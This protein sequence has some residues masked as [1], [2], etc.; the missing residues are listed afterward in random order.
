MALAQFKQI[1]LPP[2]ALPK[3]LLQIRFNPDPTATAYKQADADTLYITSSVSN[4][5]Y[6]PNKI[7][8]LA[9]LKKSFND[10]TGKITVDSFKFNVQDSLRYGGI[11]GTSHLGVGTPPI[12]TYV[13]ED[14]TS[15]NGSLFDKQIFPNDDHMCRV[16]AVFIPYVTGTPEPFFCGVIDPKSVPRAHDEIFHADESDETQ[17]IRTLEINAIDI[18]SQFNNFSIQ[19]LLDFYSGVLVPTSVSEHWFIGNVYQ[20]GGV[21]FEEMSYDSTGSAVVGNDL[22]SMSINSF[23]ATM[24]NKADIALNSGNWLASD[25]DLFTQIYDGSYHGGAYKPF[26][27]RTGTDS[28]IPSSY[29][30]DLCFQYNYNIGRGI[31]I[32]DTDD[33][34][35]FYGGTWRRDRKGSDILQ[36]LQNQFGCVFYGELTALG[37]GN[38]ATILKTST[39]R[40]SFGT[41]PTNWK[42]INKS[43]KEDP[44][45][46]SKT[47]VI[48]KYENDDTKLMAGTDDSN[49]ITI[50]MPFRAHQFGGQINSRLMDHIYCQYDTKRGRIDQVGAASIWNTPRAS[51]PDGWVPSKF[52]FVDYEFG[53]SAQTIYPYART[54][55]GSIR[56]GIAG[57]VM[58]GDSFPYNPTATNFD[59]SNGYYNWLQ[60]PAIYYYQELIGNKII[61]NREYI[62]CLSDSNTIQDLRPGIQFTLPKY[63]GKDRTFKIIEL[64][65]DLWKNK[66]KTKSQ[67]VLSSLSTPP[68]KYL[69]GSGSTSSQSSGTT[70]TAPSGLDNSLFVSTLPSSAT[71]N[72]IA[73]TVANALTIAKYGSSAGQ[74]GELRFRTLDDVHY[75]GFKAPDTLAANNIYVLPIAFPTGSPQTLFSTTGGILK[76]VDTNAL[77]TTS[78]EFLLA[79]TAGVNGYPG[80]II[81]LN[82]NGVAL[83]KIAVASANSVLLGSGSS[84]SGSTYSEITLGS[85]LTM[86]GTVLS[87]GGAGLIHITETLRTA[88]PNNT[89]NVE[90]LA[91]NSASPITTNADLSLIPRGTGAFLLATPD[92]SATGGNK[93]GTYAI[94][95]QLTRS[96]NLY[97]ASGSGSVLIG[98]TDNMAI[99][100]YAA[101]VGGS[102]NVANGFYAFVTGNANTVNNDNSAIIGG[103]S[104]TIDG[105]H[106]IILG[107]TSNVVSHNNSIASGLSMT[108]SNIGN[109]GFNA[110]GSAMTIA[111]DNTATFGNTDLWLANNTNAA[112]SLVFFAPYNTVGAFPNG[113]KFVAFKAGV[114]TTSTTYTLPLADGSA[115]YVLKT[116]GSA[117][118]SWVNPST[119][120]TSITIGNA[121]TS[122]TS[123]SIL[124]VDGSGN[125]AQDNSNFFYDATNHA[126]KIGG[127]NNLVGTVTD[128][129]VLQNTTAATSLVP[130]QFSHSLRLTG[131]RWTGS[132]SQQSDIV[133]Y[134]A[135]QSGGTATWELFISAYTGFP[136]GA[137]TILSYASGQLSL[138]GYSDGVMYFD[139]NIIKSAAL[140]GGSILFANGTHNITGNST[141]LQFSSGIL[142]VGTTGTSGEVAIISS[143]GSEYEKAQ[144]GTANFKQSFMDRIQ[145]TNNTATVLHSFSTNTGTVLTIRGYV[146][147]KQTNNNNAMQGFGGG[148]EFMITIKNI[149]GTLSTITGLSVAQQNDLV[150]ATIAPG[151]TAVV[152]G[153][154]LEI[155]FTGLT[156]SNIDVN[157]DATYR[158]A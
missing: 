19:D 54:Y 46:I 129:L 130:Q 101:V 62:G 59:D 126:V 87:A 9:T 5:V 106:S 123:G 51:I 21:G 16:Y 156:G 14:L 99:Q 32:D 132:A 141:A 43:S 48:I 75:V 151:I 96:G 83:S 124:Y 100:A 82:T 157:F 67:E 79:G 40:D 135:P 117:T 78:S 98:G 28:R 108:L 42:S 133:I 45:K 12:G 131:T 148:I 44:R 142:Q 69:D 8:N 74:L 154:A 80:T 73:G 10:E 71:R 113:T 34:P 18:L 52:L 97:V 64:E 13:F 105:N 4:N 149:G 111:R 65:I 22:M 144:S 107:G 150:I 3:G 140:S 56:V 11:I 23:L 137:T 147:Y 114:V 7:V 139:N 47:S 1:I 66:V 121:V 53:G 81:S 39:R 15:V 134:N 26:N 31:L 93:R 158:T 119:L 88:S 89:I 155:K 115:G 145:T 136:S 49:A 33:L 36:G 90:E 6:C 25:F 104:N 60:A 120:S 128:G 95:L 2:V 109:F 35:S 76:F 92:G 91:V 116:N 122:G 70:S 27:L 29:L 127:A 41:L 37:G 138:T 63:R 143:T 153:T 57:V 112:S 125:L 94:D 86:T 61:L 17:L 84:G 50:E 103:S 146:Y 30:K 102:N 38:Y 110:G 77:L 55:T 24:C 152:N 118:L 85:G 68:L 58:K 72:I 20:S